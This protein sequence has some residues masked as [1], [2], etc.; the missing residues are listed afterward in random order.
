MTNQRIDPTDAAPDDALP[1]LPLEELIA[2]AEQAQDTLSTPTEHGRGRFEQGGQKK[3]PP[4]EFSEAA[5]AEETPDRP[6]EAEED[7]EDEPPR[8]HRLWL[9]IPLCLLLVL[10]MLIAGFA[11]AVDRYF[12]YHGKR[13]KEQLTL[14]PDNVTLEV[15]VENKNVSV[16]D[17]GTTVTYQG[18]KY[19]INDSLITLLFMGVDRKNMDDV[20][21]YGT[22]GQADSVLLVVL[23]TVRGTSRI[24]NISRDTY[25]EIQLYSGGGQA[26]GFA[27]RQI[28]LAYAYGDGREK[29]CENMLT[30]VSKLLYGIPVTKYVAL[31]MEGVLAANDAVGGVTLSALQDIKM[32]DGRVVHEGEE[33]RLRGEYCERYLRARSKEEISSN[34]DRMERQIQYVRVFSSMLKQ[35]AGSDYHV[36]TALFD[37]ISPYM[38]SNLDTSD[39]IFLA[40]TYVDM[41]PNFE[42]LSIDGHYDMLTVDDHENAVYYLDETSLFE[43]ILELFYLPVD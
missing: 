7:E 11:I 25:A 42:V 40:Q 28:C 43:T 35:K 1:E 21:V 39:V 13:G 22:S 14:H 19:R 32:P 5:P 38:V 2:A 16:A 12:S 18:Q 17:D 10:A 26:L 30:A 6:P 31:D 15:P 33:I 37:E 4:R 20:S 8:K 41:N 34:R 3:K 24:L 9:R 36:I 27:K 23:D 29:S